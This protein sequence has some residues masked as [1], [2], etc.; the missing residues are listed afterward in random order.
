[1][2]ARVLSDRPNEV[3][4]SLFLNVLSVQLT[5]ELRMG[6]IR[7]K[8]S[9]GEVSLHA[10]GKDAN[11]QLPQ[12]GF[13]L[14]PVAL[15]AKGRIRTLRLIPAGGPVKTA[16][17]QRSLQIGAVSVIPVNSTNRMQL[18]PSPGSGMTLQLVAH[19]ELAGVELSPTFQVAQ[20]LLKDQHQPIRVTMNA[21][22]EDGGT[23]F[24]AVTVGLDQ[25]ACI[26]ELLLTPVSQAAA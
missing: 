12:T 20:V 24:E 8:P 5:P 26:S 25:A 19:L 21:G 2:A 3:V 4:L 15:D 16:P 13:R 18:T 11:E 14:G 9:S 10:I 17:T 1:M 6:S 7:A 23:T 22:R